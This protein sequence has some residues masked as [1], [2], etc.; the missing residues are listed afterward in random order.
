MRGSKLPMPDLVVI[1]RRA[2][3]EMDAWLHAGERG[4]LAVIS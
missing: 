2:G 1:L 4:A 3:D